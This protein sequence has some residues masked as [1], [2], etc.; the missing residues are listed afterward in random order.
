M[1]GPLAGVVVTVTPTFAEA[2][3]NPAWDPARAER[4]FSE[5]LVE[6]AAAYQPEWR[7]RYHAENP[8][9]L[10]VE[11]AVEGAYL[12]RDMRAFVRAVAVWADFARRRF[13][14][15]SKGGSTPS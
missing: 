2:C 4:L 1:E 11:A 5:A 12:L 8:R 6:V 10:E 9:W 7:D 13:E 14:A 3:R 15:W